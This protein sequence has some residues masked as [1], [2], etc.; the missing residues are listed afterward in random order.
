MW[1]TSSHMFRERHTTCQCALTMHHFEPTPT[2]NT[3]QCHS[4]PPLLSTIKETPTE[5][6]TRRHLA[7]SV[8]IYTVQNQRHLAEI[9]LTSILYACSGTKSWPG[10]RS[11][12]GPWPGPTSPRMPGTS[13]GGISSPARWSAG[14]RMT[15]GASCAWAGCGSGRGVPRGESQLKGQEVK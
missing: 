12:W 13:V 10:R 8:S 15:C 4:V 2:Q 1:K 14:A 6:T 9:T 7:P 5:N 3:A 11:S